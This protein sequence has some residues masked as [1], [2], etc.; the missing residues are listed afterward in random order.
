MPPSGERSF[1][2][3]DCYD[4]LHQLSSHFKGYGLSSAHLRL[5]RCPSGEQGQN[6]CLRVGGVC[7]GKQALQQRA[8][9][10]C[11]S[12][13]LVGYDLHFSWTLWFPYWGEFCDLVVRPS[14]PRVITA[15]KALGHAKAWTRYSYGKGMTKWTHR[16]EILAR[17]E[18]LCSLAIQDSQSPITF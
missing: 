14:H 11:D 1:F 9:E 12:K 17:S 5:D 7:E 4:T 10:T 16:Q 6:S 2:T 3:A 8:E 15:L 18:W 13:S